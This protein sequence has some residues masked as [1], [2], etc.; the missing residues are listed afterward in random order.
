MITEGTEKILGWRSPNYLYSSKEGDLSVI[1]K[2]YRLSDDIAF[3]FSNATW[4]E[5]PLTAEKYADWVAKAPGDYIGLFMDYETFGEH[6]WKE[7]GIFDFMKALPEQLESKGVGFLT[8]SEIAAF[9]PKEPLDVPFAISW[10]DV[11]RDVSAWLD[12]EMQHE[13]FN[14]VK[15]LEQRVKE[16]GDKEL[17]HVWRLLQTS[18]HLYYICLKNFSDAE[19]H[20]YFSPY[21]S[22][23]RA[24]MNYMSVIQDLKRRLYQ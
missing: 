12:N 16:K 8:P 7:S 3:R 20:A 22:P 6:Q 24:F 15:D 18:D 5:Y 13:C 11:E 2:N 19:V 4:N 17:L 14:E 10:A 21:D 1:L 23:Y 9:A